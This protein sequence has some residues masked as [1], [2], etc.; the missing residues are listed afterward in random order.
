MMTTT[1]KIKKAAAAAIILVFAAAVLPGASLAGE[2]DII[3]FQD[4]IIKEEL[5]KLPGA[6]ANADGEFTEGELAALAGRLSVTGSGIKDITG[7]QFA[8]GLTE[9]DLSGNKIRDISCLASLVSSE[10]HNLTKLNVSQN[11]LDLTAGS[12]D[13]AVIDGL[14]SAGCAVT[15]EPQKAVAVEGITLDRESLDMYPGDTVT[16]S[17]FIS[18]ADAADKAVTWSSD[19]E[20]VATV[21]DGV[22][23][24]AAAGKANITA[25]SD[26]GGFTAVLT[27][28]VYDVKLSSAKYIVAGGYV[29]NVGKST[30]VDVFKSYFKNNYSDLR[31]FDPAGGECYSGLITSG[32]T[33]KL[34]I[35][36]EPAD[37]AV[38][39]VRGDVNGDGLI[40]ILDYTCTRFHILEL[41]TLSGAFAKSADADNNGIVDILDYTTIRF[42]ILDLERI[43]GPLPD[44]PEVTDPRIREF[45]DIALAQI[46]KPY[47]L[48]NEGP[49]SFD[50]SGLVYYCLNQAGY[51]VGRSTANTYSQKTQWQLVGRDDLQPGDLMFYFSDKPDAPEGYIGHVGIYLGNG[52]HIHA[53]SANMH[54]VIC[55]VNNWYDEALSHGRRVFN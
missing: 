54:I 22:V 31:V 26:D 12:G 8:A 13:M 15:Y 51:S 16:L 24:A 17:A 27:V 1:D 19:N 48:G 35:K 9:L 50:C 21:T 49:D 20:S 5:L 33:V 41:E 6:D 45:L 37:E 30:V 38:I 47:V 7:M 40:D 2:N 36:G 10:P 34:Y 23:T 3:L 42:D 28:T 43:G 14:I 52:Y 18:P 55:R 25:M 44:L 46:G 32:M 4:D 53:S 29:A 39:L 11:Y